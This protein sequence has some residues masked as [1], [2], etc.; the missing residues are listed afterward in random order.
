M[1]NK[2]PP[3][4][5]RSTTPPVGSGTVYRPSRKLPPLVARS[6][7]D[8][9]SEGTSTAHSRRTRIGYLRRSHEVSKTRRHQ[10]DTSALVCATASR[11]GAASVQARETLGM[12]ETRGVRARSGS[13]RSL[14][15]RG[16]PRPGRSLAEIQLT[17]R[18]T[19]VLSAP[20]ISN[21]SGYKEKPEMARSAVAGLPDYPGEATAFRF[22]SAPASSRLP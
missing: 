12:D 11:G 1:G 22:Q 2:Q 18:E 20:A 3:T 21:A 13:R 9:G 8:P 19:R 17:I 7:R 16:T 4:T 15:A 10:I 14:L 5:P 6:V